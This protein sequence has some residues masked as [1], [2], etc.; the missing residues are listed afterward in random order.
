MNI[1]AL[2]TA[3]NDSK[4]IKNKNILNIRGK[5]CYKWNLEYAK[6]C[7]DIDKV[8]ISTD[9]PSI[10]TK[11]QNVIKR[12][13]HLCTDQASHYDTIMHGLQQIENIEKTHVDILIILLGNNV[14][15]LTED[16]TAG[17]N[18]IKYNKCDSCISVGAYNMYNPYRAYKINSNYLL[19]TIVPQHIIR[20]TNVKQTNN[21]DAFG[22]VYF[23]NGSFWICRRE[24]LIAN[25]GLLPFPWLGKKIK[26][27]VQKDTIME[28]DAPWQIQIVQNA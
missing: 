24:T 12:P 1:F 28:L 5:P 10:I 20:K 18:Y 6:K 11:E 19:E 15:A 26:P 23:F 2:Q 13:K 4:S 9:I 21:K 27:I 14:G 25:N 16:L 3:R 22:N 8:Y 17:I 7:S